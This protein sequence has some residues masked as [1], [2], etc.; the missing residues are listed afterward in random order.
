MGCALCYLNTIDRCCLI[1]VQNFLGK[2]YFKFK[3]F[4]LAKRPMAKSLHLAVREFL[5]RVEVL[6]WGSAAAETYGSLHAE[7]VSQGK[8]LAL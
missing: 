2:I 6:P 3:L 8:T 7:L 5:R 4:G 1:N